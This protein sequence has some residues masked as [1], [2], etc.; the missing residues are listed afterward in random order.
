MHAKSVMVAPTS[1]VDNTSISQFKRLSARV[2]RA[3]LDPGQDDETTVLK[4]YD[5]VFKELVMREGYKMNGKFG[6]GTAIDWAVCYGIQGQEYVNEVMNTLNYT[7]L[8]AALLLTISLPAYV[9]PPDF[10]DDTLGHTFMAFAGISSLAN[11]L[12][13]LAATVFV[14]ILTRPYANVDTFIARLDPTLFAMAITFDYVGVATLLALMLCAGFNRSYLD[15][16]IQL[17]CGAIVLIIIAAWIHAWYLGDAAQLDR[18]ALFKQTYCDH[19][20][21]LK[22]EYLSAIY[23][24]ES[25]ADLLEGINCKQYLSQFEQAGLV[26]V[27]G[28]GSDG[29]GGGDGDGDGGVKLSVVVMMDKDDLIE[30]GITNIKDRLN[31]I[32]EFNRVKE[33]L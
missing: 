24:P 27:A 9:D 21:Q 33:L 17:Y 29:D 25:L 13:I 5:Q 15:G 30:I 19:D 6:Q 14:T 32:A 18:V 8:H 3:V 31:I 26:A 23:P 2:G 12:S 1:A 7:V 22:D 11:L 28:K 20:G 10:N 4:R 16:Y